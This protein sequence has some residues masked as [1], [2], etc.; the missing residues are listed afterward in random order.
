MWSAVSDVRTSNQC[1]PKRNAERGAFTEPSG[2]ADSAAPRG[3]GLLRYWLVSDPQLLM[4]WVRERLT[5]PGEKKK[6][7]GRT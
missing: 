3:P 6:R 4:R 1:F 5:G 7:D 2:E